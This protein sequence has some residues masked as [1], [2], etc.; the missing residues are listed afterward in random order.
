MRNLKKALS[1]FLCAV[2]LFTTLCFFP[3]VTDVTAEAAVVNSDNRTALYVP[4]MIYLYPDVTSWTAAVKTPFQYYVNNAVDTENIYSA[5]E[6]KAEADSEGKIYFAA[7]EGMSGY[8]LVARF[9]DSDGAYIDA[10]D[11]GSVSFTAADMGDYIMFTVTEGMSPLLQATDSGCYIEWCLTYTDSEGTDKAVFAYTYVYKPYVV[12]YGA[13]AR[14]LNDKDDVNVYGQAITWV[15]GVHSADNTAVQTN[16]LY[17]RYIPVSQ[18]YDSSDNTRG[19]YPFSPF[20][21]KN[22]KAFVG[23]VQVSGS[24]PVANGGYNAVFAGSNEETAYFWAN[25]DGASFTRSYRVREF[26]YTAAT[27]ATYPVAFDY[28]NNSAVSAQYALTQVTPMRIGTISVDISRYDNLNEIPNLAVGMM[29]TDTDVDD[30]VTTNV[31]T[32]D[33]QWY[34]GDA[35]GRTHLATG[36]Y[37][38]INNINSARDAVYVKFASGKDLTAPLAKGIWYAG[39]WNKELNKSEGVNTYTVKS[40][41]ETEDREGDRQAISS[42]VSLNVN[43]TDKSALREAVNNATLLFGAFGAKSNWNSYYYDLNASDWSDFEA[44][45]K[46]ASM[47]LCNVEFSGDAQALIEALDAAVAS[48]TSGKGMR[49]YFDVN[50][51]DIGINLWINPSTSYYLWDAENEAAVIDGTFFADANYGTT[52]FTPDAGSYIFNVTQLSGTFNG[53]GCVVFDSVDENGS[54]ALKQSGNRYNFDFEGSA[55]KV[56]SYEEENFVNVEGLR[57]WSWYYST[58]GDGVYNDFAVRIKIEKGSTATAYSPVGKVTGTSYG[59]LPV[60]QREGYLF[61]GWY[62]DEALENQVTDSSAVS[63]RILYAKWEKAKYNVVFD[64]NGADGGESP[65]QTM[66]Y[67]EKAALNPNGYTRTG[68]VFAGWTDELGNTYA[69][70]EE[71]LNLTSVHE[72]KYTLYAQWTANQYSIAFDGNT[73]LGGLGM[74]NAQYDNFIEL[75]ANYFIKTGYTFAGWATTPDGEAVYADGQSVKNLTSDVDGSVTLYAVWDANEFTVSFDKNGGDGAMADAVVSYDS[76]VS[77]PVC[78]FTKTGYSFIGWSLDASG[79]VLITDTQYDVLRTENGDKVTLYAVWSENSY[80]LN[81]D[82]NGGEGASIPATVYKYED[83]VNLPNNV[84]T[85]D[86][87]ILAGWSLT[88]DGEIVYANGETVKH[89]NADKNG[90]V[91]LY[92]VWTPVSY[93]VKFDANTGAGD[94]AAETMIYDV[95]EALP[96]NGFTKEGYHFIGWATAPAGGVAYSDAQT[97]KNL[98]KTN[99]AAITLYAVWEINT[100]KVTLSYYNDQGIWAT[101]EISVAHGAAAELPADFSETPYCNENGHYVFAGWTGDISSVT[102]SMTVSGKYQSTEVHSIKVESTES[103]CSQPGYDRYYCEKCSYESYEWKSLKAHSFDEGNIAIQPGCTTSG[104]RVSTC[105]VCF[106]TKAETVNPTG[107]DFVSFPYNAPTCKEEGNIAHKHCENCTKCFAIDAPDDTPDSQALTDEQVKIDKLPH[108]P[109]AD[110]TC[111]EDQTCTVCGE[112]VTARLGHTETTEYVTTDATCTNAGTYVKKVSCTV[113]SQPISEETLYG[114]IPHAYESV[115]TPPTCTDAGY[116]TYTCSVCLASYTEEDEAANGHTEGEWIETTAPGC[117]DNG[118]ETNYC[119]ICDA[120]WKTRETSAQGHDSGEWVVIIPAKCEEWGTEALTCTKCSAE[121]STR[122]ISPKGHGEVR[123]EIT[124]APG[125]ETAGKNSRIC[126][127]CNNELSFTVIPETGHNPKNAVTCEND[128]VCDGCG[129]VLAPRLGHDWDNGA[130]TKEPTET[131]T[132]IMTYTCKNDVSH[133]REESIPVRIVIV[134]PEITA[135]DA[136]ETGFIGNIHN[137]ITVEEGMEYTVI[138]SAQENISM[139]ENGNMVAHKDGSAEITVVTADGK[140]T[141]TFTI[142]AR[143]L[144]SVIF[145]I[146]GQLTEIRA[147]VGDKVTAPQVDAYTEGNFTYRFK[148]WTL[149]GVVTNNFTVTGNMTFVAVYTSSCDYTQLDKLADAFVRLIDGSQAN[150]DKIKIYKSEIDAAVVR[151]EEFSKDRD[152]RD[153]SDQADIDAFTNELSALISKIY[154]ENEGRLFIT[155]DSRVELS[156]ITE[157]TAFLSPINTIVTDGIWTSSDDGVGFFI[158]NKFHAV[159]AGTITV[160]VSSGNRTA[161]KEITVAGGTAARVIMFDSLVFNANYIIEGSYV[162]KETTNIFWDPY[163]PL[164]FRVITDGTFEDYIVY[165]NDKVATPDVTGT[166]TIEGGTGDTQVRIEG[167]VKDTDGEK[168][169]IWEMISNFFKKIADFFRNLFS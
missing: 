137:M 97:V 155:N 26:F 22:N 104:S 57:F 94:M 1:V 120:P 84:F 98:S 162:I 169:S 18:A 134:I 118:V 86:G 56:I 115:V 153:I 59:T 9:V 150:A 144:K 105:G 70:G 69:D 53:A 44:A 119:A 10:A 168:L 64:G 49:V 58:E 46:A 100:Y 80:T 111:T 89:I 43:Q 145:D 82:K 147:Y 24:A 156:S 77:L 99:G 102:A 165:V 67:D 123:Y 17:P 3:L 72:G 122:G 146:R 78:E 103:T 114:T 65:E 55:V 152:I 95:S 66:T 41:Y 109:G 31:A 107:H 4:E 25:Q 16:T 27:T 141:K 38:S 129:I 140:F 60:P 75:P 101:V 88:R 39:A 161:S 13:A 20:L 63:A 167:L 131:E 42:A 90:V 52:A 130:V 92:A 48:L 138:I 76:G 34:I 7:E 143:T 32:A 8:E 126:K 36:A 133:T 164:H 110:A 159:R 121:I 154:P 30:S 35:T 157:F 91:T 113:C 166:Y 124:V 127:D 37:D 11:T 85:K 62:A 29:V 79:D 68:Y 148:S 51:D 71:V 12:P 21:S 73:G 81:L 106:A 93:T 2:M 87:Y 112:V 15:S 40:Y 142:T 23:G 117:I 125:C 14:V 160:T 136:P 163:A 33:A 28:M 132:G 149:N 61:A 6:T 135:F 5:P 96:A 54:N 45:F 83:S 108:T 158:G 47:A 19:E 50:Y 139:D 74:A 116:I 128:S 151:I